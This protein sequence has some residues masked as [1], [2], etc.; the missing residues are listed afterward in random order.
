LSGGYRHPIVGRDVLTGATWAAACILL[1]PALIRGLSWLGL[2]AP[3][4]LPS[5]FDVLLAPRRYVSFV[6]GSQIDALVLGLGALLLFLVFRLL[7][8]RDDAA[9]VALTLV[10]TVTQVTQM[11]AILWMRLVL[12]LVLMTAYAVLLLR[13]GLLS[14]VAAIYVSHLLTGTPYTLQLGSWQSGPTVATTVLVAALAIS[15]FRTA[16][17]AHRR[18]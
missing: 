3:D 12:G 6:L 2:F 1:I 11:D 4:V 7:L 15:A 10:L 17:R 14:A 5:N 8:K 16:T 18:A 13:L 9:G